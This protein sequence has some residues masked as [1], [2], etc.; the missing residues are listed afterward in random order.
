[1]LPFELLSSPLHQAY[2]GKDEDG[3]PLSRQYKMTVRSAERT[4]GLIAISDIPMV[5]QQ[6]RQK[7]AYH[8]ASTSPE[9]LPINS[10]FD[11]AQFS[12]LYGQAACHISCG[13]FTF[14]SH[15]AE[16]SKKIEAY[17]EKLILRGIPIAFWLHE[18]EFT[19][20][21]HPERIVQKRLKELKR[22][23]TQETWIQRVRSSIQKN[24]E[25]LLAETPQ[26]KHALH[27]WG[28][29]PHSLRE[30]IHTMRFK[31]TRKKQKYS[32]LHWILMWDLA[33]EGQ[34]PYKG[35][36]FRQDYGYQMEG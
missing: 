21:K 24:L 3:L 16:A 27:T 19:Q 11:E 30:H 36:E 25:S 34:L 1:F 17:L 20:A 31:S 26:L 4:F 7:S 18:D 9:L 23:I 5:M 32:G 2:F 10:E 29:A 22:H 15:T 14:P 13:C 12:E 35:Q 8:Q 28:V 6:W 33:D